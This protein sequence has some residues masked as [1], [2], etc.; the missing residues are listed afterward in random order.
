MVRRSNKQVRYTISTVAEM[1]EIHPQTLRMYEREGLIEPMRSEGKTRLYEEKDLEKLEI[2][3]TLTRDMGINLAGV[4]VIIELRQK[5]HL[6]IERLEQMEE[7]LSSD[8]FEELRQKIEDATPDMNALIP[9]IG[10]KLMK[11]KREK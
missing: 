7:V 4:E 8:A 9:S 11:L 3:L 6:A 5:L 1:F 2:I 10:A